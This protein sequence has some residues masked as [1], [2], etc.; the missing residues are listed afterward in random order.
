MP[1]VP[2]LDEHG[3]L[4]VDTADIVGHLEYGMIGGCSACGHTAVHWWRMPA[5]EYIPVHEGC[6]HRLVA[7]WRERVEAGD[8]RA[9]DLAAGARRGAYARRA[10]PDGSRVHPPRPASRRSR[11][12]GSPFFR[13]GMP[14]GAPWVIVVESHHGRLN[15]VHGDD[16]VHARAVLGHY[17]ALTGR[18]WP[19]SWGGPVAVGAVLLDPSGAVVDRWGEEFDLAAPSPWVRPD[20]PRPVVVEKPGKRRRA[21]AKDRV[22]D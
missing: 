15:F 4:A 2:P 16:E 1:P 17:E 9:P 5:G 21:G 12:L 19:I 10:A 22:Y 11:S 18:G 3:R 13:P 7:G 20:P 6:A 8:L 14:E